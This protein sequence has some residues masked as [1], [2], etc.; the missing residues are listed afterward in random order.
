MAIVT[1]DDEL[2]PTDMSMSLEWNNQVFT[3]PY[4]GKEQFTERSGERWIFKFE[5]KDMEEEQA[6]VLAAFLNSMKGVIGRFYAKDFSFHTNRGRISGTPVV[7]GSDNYGSV[8]KIANAPSNRTLFER[9]D[10]VK[11]G[12]RLHMLTEKITSDSAGK[13]TLVFQPPMLSVPVANSNIVY[14]DFTVICRLKDNNQG[15]RD[16]ADVVNSF[17]FEAV[18]VL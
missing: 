14:D 17:S 15:M 1:L 12:S 11:I 2:Y 8:C 5:Y 9:G 18:E 10:Y 7:D 4:N 16:S 6:R 3:S 13:A